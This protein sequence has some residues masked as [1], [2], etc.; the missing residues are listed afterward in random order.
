MRKHRQKRRKERKGDK[1]QVGG[2]GE[3]CRKEEWKE[4]RRGNTQVGRRKG[5]GK[6]KGEEEG[7]GEKKEGK[8]RARLH[9]IIIKK[10]DIKE[11]YDSLL[12]SIIKKK[13]NSSRTL[14]RSVL[15]LV[16]FSSFRL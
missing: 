6:N 10:K 8:E 9:R 7:R 14:L 11:N 1:Q 2:N 4:R 15:V 12:F 13:K 16:L 3:R 5:G